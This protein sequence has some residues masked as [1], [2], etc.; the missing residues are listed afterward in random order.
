MCARRARRARVSP[1]SETPPGRGRK[2]FPR[3]A[4]EHPRTA[5]TRVGCVLGGGLLHFPAGATAGK[6]TDGSRQRSPRQG[7]PRR[8]SP[9]PPLGLRSMRGSAAGSL[10]GQLR[11][12]HCPVANTSGELKGNNAPLYESGTDGNCLGRGRGKQTQ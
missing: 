11:R 3:W 12:R 8:G 1:P 4:T 6:D 5:E 7:S 10:H 2:E 9:P